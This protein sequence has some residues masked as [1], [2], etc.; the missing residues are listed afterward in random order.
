MAL[1]T[2]SSTLTGQTIAASYD[3][4]LFLDSA[5]GV[6][7]ATLKIVSGTAGKTALSISDEHV[8]VKGVDT[9]NAA[10]F[11]VQQ[12]DG[13]SILKIAADTPA[14]TLIAPL[15]IGADDAG[16]DVIFY[17]NT[18]S[19]NMTW[20]TS[21]DDLVLNDSRLYINQDDDEQSI[22]VDSEATSNNIVSINGKFAMAVTQDIS[23][24]R[25]LYI[26]RDIAETGSHSLVSMI[27]D[28]ASN[29]QPSLFI[30]QDGAGYG[31]QIDQNGN[32]N[33]MRI[34]SAATTNVAAIQ[35]HADSITTGKI[36]YFYSDASNTSTRSLVSIINDNASATGATALTIQ[37]DSTGK[38]ISATGGIVEEGGTLKENLI[39]NSGFDVW[40]N[41]TL[42]D[43]D[44]THYGGVFADTQESSAY[45]WDT[46]S[47]VSA[48]GFRA[49]H[50][51]SGDQ[52]CIAA[53]SGETVGKLYRLSFSQSLAS[54]AHPYYGIVNAGTDSAVNQTTAG[55][56][57]LVFEASSTTNYIIF[58]SD[59]NTDFTISSLTL[60]EVTPGCVAA[61]ADDK[62]F[63]G[64]EKKTDCD[65]R[66]EHNGSNTKDGSFYSLKLTGGGA[67]DFDVNLYLTEPA[68][69]ERYVG[70]TVTMGCWVKAGAASEV[71]IGFYDGSWTYG[72]ENTTS[73]WEWLEYTKTLADN[74]SYRFGLEVDNGEVVYISQPMMVFGSSIGEGNYTRPQG[75]VVWLDAKDDLTDF[76]ASTI[77]SDTSI[78]LE[79][80]SRGKLPKGAKAV[81]GSFIGQASAVDTEAVLEPVLLGGVHGIWVIASVAT[82]RYASGS[83]WI[84]CDSSGDIAINIA[85]GTWADARIRIVGVELR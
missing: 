10:G 3:Q 8:L 26:T 51:S 21:E 1:A 59:A 66:R 53:I 37:Q 27:N 34:D 9:N 22:V 18:A 80:Q 7:E 79:A 64:W 11:E 61:D 42:E 23:G 55:A 15:T 25:G 52:M 12:T 33:S 17:G 30:Q 69:V 5:S 63:D 49:V 47:G 38:A 36:A 32:A 2:P 16:H 19:S 76:T 67:T 35:A 20:D 6:T 74:Q 84:P 58:R 28:N 83:G 78:N 45:A 4:V 54:G 82:P 81:Y 56:Q 65:L 40:S 73:D 72:S 39:T 43:V 41:S 14:A 62:A 13:T 85:S 77:S 31:I 68:E 44:T 71:K 24:G 60:R 48:A 29:T 70:R 75:E 50:S 46:F 57:T